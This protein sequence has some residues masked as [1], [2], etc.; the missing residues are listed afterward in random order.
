MQPKKFLL[1]ERRVVFFQADEM[2]WRKTKLEKMG[3]L[4]DRDVLQFSCHEVS[5]PGTV[6]SDEMF[7]ARIYTM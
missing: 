6:H 2:K 3:I 4:C 5:N 7:L 1:S